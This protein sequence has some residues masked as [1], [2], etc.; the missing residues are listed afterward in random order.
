MNQT[1]SHNKETELDR[2]LEVLRQNLRR[3]GSVLVAYSGGLDSTFLALVAHEELGERMCAVTAASGAHPAWEREEAVS[4]A[5]DRGIPHRLITT[6]EL[7]VSAFRNNTADRCYHCKKEL[8]GAFLAL[9]EV[10]GLS[11]VADGTTVDDCNDYRPGRRAVAELGVASP[12]LEAGFT[13]RDVRIA[14]RGMGLPTWDKPAFACLAS[15]FPYGETITA[16]KLQAVETVENVLR[17]HGF[18]QYRVRCHAE[19][20]RIEVLPEDIERVCEPGLRSELVETAGQVGF[21]YISVDLQGY[22]TGSMNEVLDAVDRM[23]N[24]SNG[25]GRPS[26]SV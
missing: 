23:P 5:V 2:K 1:G 19:V 8:F 16:E 6:S 3:Y 21:H 13:R 15:R 9:A 10:E 14:S 17:R 22:R 11:I 26:L 24:V 7:Q 4:L 12:L 18:R 20:A 25:D